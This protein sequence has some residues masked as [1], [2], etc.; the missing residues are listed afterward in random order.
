MELYSKCQILCWVC[1]KIWM[2]FLNVHS[3]FMLYAPQNE[4][5]D[6]SFELRKGLQ[7]F[8]AINKTSWLGKREKKVR[9]HENTSSTLPP[10][11]HLWRF[12]W[13]RSMR[14]CVFTFVSGATSLWQRHRA[15]LALVLPFFMYALIKGWCSSE[16]NTSWHDSSHYVAFK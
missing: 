2:T 11:L 13:M 4:I 16:G 3:N 6:Y 10:S 12:P 1:T 14:R 5:N 15:F 7:T 9:W 8:I